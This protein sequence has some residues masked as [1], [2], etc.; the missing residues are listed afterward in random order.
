MSIKP[1]FILMRPANIVTSVADILAGLSIA[2]VLSMGL[3]EEAALLILSTVGLYGGGIVFNDVFDVE[4][5]RIER[6][7]R[8]L[9]S[10]Q[11]SLS[12]AQFLGGFL[13]LIGI[14][15]AFLVNR[16]SGILAIT[17]ALLALLYDKFSKHHRIFG[18]INMGLCRSFNLLLGISISISALST[19]WW[20]AIIPLLFIA[21]ITLTSQGE[22][23]GDNIST[24]YLAFLLDI[25]VIGLFIASYFLSDF[26]LIPAL[27]FLVLW[28]GMNSL[29]K[30]K[31]I[32]ENKPENIQNAVKMGV[33]SLIPLDASMA[34]GF[35]G[36]LLGLIVLLLLPLSLTLAK[37]FSVT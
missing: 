32:R 25:A 7:E 9:P 33:L 12:Q 11:I 19:F 18:A 2:G 24:L 36:L 34:A 13:L 26:Q 15:T 23:K 3:N 35:E 14:S 8:P 4:L 20:L 37:Y 28:F 1:Y 21:A 22:V 6:P 16:Y 27:P 31:A 17:I 30:L 10:G 5:D 29:S